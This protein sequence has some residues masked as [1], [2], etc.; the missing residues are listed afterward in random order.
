MTREVIVNR[1]DMHMSEPNPMK[2]AI[3]IDAENVLPIHGDA[4]FSQAESLG[5]VTVK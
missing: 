4:I 5:T 3:L 1:S 2:L